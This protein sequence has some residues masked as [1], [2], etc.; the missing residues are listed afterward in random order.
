[1]AV[2]GGLLTRAADYR[3]AV[4]ARIRRRREVSRVVVVA[5]PAESA[6]RAAI[7]LAATTTD[8]AILGREAQL[9]CEA[10]DVDG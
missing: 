7:D 10:P 2:A 3:E 1:V 9:S 5:H 4:L 8:A 6:A